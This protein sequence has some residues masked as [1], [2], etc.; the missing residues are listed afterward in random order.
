MEE[1]KLEKYIK[2]SPIPIFVEGIETIL[3]QMKSCICKIYKKNITGTGFFCKIPFQNKLLPVLITNN[4]VLKEEDIKIG[5]QIE[6][7]LNNNKE[8]REIK[9]NNTRKILTTGKP[10]ITIIEIKPN[11]DKIKNFLEIDKDTNNN[12]DIIEL[13]Y[14][15]KSIYVLHYPES[16]NMQVSF[17]LLN[18][19]YENDINHYCTTYGGSSGSPILSLETFKVIGIHYASGSNQYNKG[20]FI[21]N[22]INE[23]NN[24]YQNLNEEKINIFIKSKKEKNIRIILEKQINLGETAYSLC[25][26]KKQ[27]LIAIGIDKKIFLYDYLNFDKKMEGDLLDNKV[28]YIY[29]MKNGNLL[30]TDLSNSINI[31]H[32]N[33]DE[34]ELYQKI[35]TPNEVNFIGIELN[36][37]KIICGGTQYL[38]IIEESFLFG[39]TL[40]CS[41]D[42]KSFI[43]NLVELNSD[44]YLIGLSQSKTIIIYSNKNNSEICQ[45]KVNLSGNNYSI[46]KITDNYVAIAGYEENEE[47]VQI[48]CIYIFSIQQMIICKKVYLNNLSY[49]VLILK[50]NDN[51][52]IS[53]GFKK[54]NKSQ[55]L[56]LLN[57]DKDNDKINIIYNY[58]GA[59]SDIIEAIN[60]INNELFIISDSLGNLKEWKINKN[61]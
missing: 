17:G 23:F 40:T 26:L 18:N 11:E 16:K 54:G 35:S 24:K 3:F 10:D 5:K 49:C 59:H 37:E 29:E 2:S 46:S 42:L 25:Y 21:Q 13:T 8:K 61:G 22:A 39:Y 36:D 33:K 41:I 1:I 55:D 7:T 52:F 45:I 28:S 20:I 57:Y 43:N 31:L 56:F 60:P 44:L 6:L 48:G 9:I 15:S 34:I 47:K 14:R 4:H 32:I 38:C 27:K 12:K 58:K 53:S 19:I 51:E 30:C 50:L